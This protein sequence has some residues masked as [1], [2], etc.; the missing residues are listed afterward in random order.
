MTHLSLLQQ[1]IADAR[2]ITAWMV[3]I[4]CGDTETAHFVI[5]DRTEQ[6]ATKEAMREVEQHYAGLDWTLS[7]L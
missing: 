2:R 6:Q 1:S 7:K 5:N 4:Y 3:R